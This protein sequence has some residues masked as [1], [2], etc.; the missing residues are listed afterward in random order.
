LDDTRNEEQAERVVLAKGSD[1][2]D[3]SQ[4]LHFVQGASIEEGT[5]HL[6][7]S[8][9]GGCAEHD[10]RLVAW[11]SYWKGRPPRAELLLAHDANGDSCKALIREEL[12]FDLSPLKAQYHRVYGPEPGIVALRL[13]DLDV[14]YYL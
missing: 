4:D 9:T 8:Y 5:L 1:P 7:V 3:W 10:F 2:E 12:R 6:R 11:D 13:G 14:E